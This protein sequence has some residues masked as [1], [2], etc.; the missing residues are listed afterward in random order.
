MLGQFQAN[1]GQKV[2][3][4]P[5]LKNGQEFC[6]KGQNAASLFTSYAPSGSFNINAMRS[7]GVANNENVARGFMSANAENFTEKSMFMAAQG[8]TK[9]RSQKQEFMGCTRDYDCS[10]NKVCNMNSQDWGESF[11]KFAP[12]C[13]EPRYPELATGKFVREMAQN[14]GIGA[15]CTSDSNCAT[16]KGYR[17]APMSGPGTVG[18]VTQGGYCAQTFTC[19]SETKYLKYPYGSEFPMSPSPSDNNFGR[20][21]SSMK[22]CSDAND[23]GSKTRHCKKDSTGRWFSVN[24]GYCPAITRDASTQSLV[25]A[26]L[27]SYSDKINNWNKS[28]DFSASRGAGFDPMNYEAS[29]NVPSHMTKF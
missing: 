5:V 9:I 3:N 1:P 16:N 24:P 26:S 2:S 12:Y 11:G 15:Q 25:S 14:G 13:T 28:E 22:E 10:G 17:C 29:I 27:S 23:F 19:G 7:I 18:P 6:T 8:A 21:Y 4:C 20:G